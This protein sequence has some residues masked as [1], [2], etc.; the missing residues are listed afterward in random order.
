MREFLS[1]EVVRAGVVEVVR[2]DVVEVVG[3]V[4][5]EQGQTLVCGGGARLQSKLLVWAPRKQVEKLTY[6]WSKESNVKWVIRLRVGVKAACDNCQLPLS[7][8]LEVGV[9]CA[10]YAP[11]C[12]EASLLNKPIGREGHLDKACRKRVD[13]VCVQGHRLP[14]ELYL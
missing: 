8:P 7:H 12:C 10:E 1:K 3:A 5:E 4:F 14:Q 9:G 11:R 13:V 2:A 6:D